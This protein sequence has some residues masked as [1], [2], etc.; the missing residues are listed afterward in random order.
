MPQRPY[1]LHTEFDGGRM[2][3]AYGPALPTLKVARRA[4]RHCAR[5]GP[6]AENET[7]IL[8][9]DTTGAIVDSFTLAPA[10]EAAP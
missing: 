2:T 7:A 8:V 4:A 5:R 6:L 9:V 1:T 3:A 10:V